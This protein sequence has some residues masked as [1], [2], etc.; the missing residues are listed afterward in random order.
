[1]ILRAGRKLCRSHPDLYDALRETLTALDE[2]KHVRFPIFWK[3]QL[4]VCRSLGFELQLQYDALSGKL[5]KLPISNPIRFHFSDGTF[6]EDGGTK[7]PG[8]GVLT[9]ESFAILLRLSTASRDFAA[10]LAVSPKAEK[11]ITSFLSRYLETHLPIRGRLRSLEALR[12]SRA[13]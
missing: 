7:D 9:A 10:R 5:F 4:D 8:D 1:L 13:H 6:T 2:Q 11:E 12:W 3:F